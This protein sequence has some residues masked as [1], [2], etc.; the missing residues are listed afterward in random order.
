MRVPRGPRHGLAAGGPSALGAS[1]SAGRPEAAVWEPGCVWRGR[2]LQGWAEG[3]RR[4]RG[5]PWTLLGAKES[6]PK[7]A[8]HRSGRDSAAINCSL[9]PSFPPSFHSFFHPHVR[10]CGQRVPNRRH[11]GCDRVPGPAAG[12]GG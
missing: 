10:T 4:L 9:S 7:Q 1:P 11:R 6:P 12:G 5:Q 8:P 2:G 3:T